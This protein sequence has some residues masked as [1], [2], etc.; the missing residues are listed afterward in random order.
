MVI[1]MKSIYDDEN[2]RQAVEQFLPVCSLE[3]GEDFFTDDEGNKDKNC[4]RQY[5]VVESLH[6]LTLSDDGLKKCIEK[7]T[8][9]LTPR[10]M[11]G[12]HADIP[13]YTI[14]LSRR[15]AEDGRLLENLKAWL[16]SDGDYD[17]DAWHHTTC[18][19][20]LPILSDEYSGKPVYYGKAQKIVNMTVK[21]VYSL[22]WVN[23]KAASTPQEQDILRKL[24]RKFESAHIPLDRFTLEWFHRR[25]AGKKTIHPRTVNGRTY[26]TYASTHFPSWSSLSYGTGAHCFLPEDAT[27]DKWQYTYPFAVEEV[28]ALFGGEVTVDGAVVSQDDPK[29]EYGS[30][31]DKY[32]GYAPLQAEF[33]IWKEMQITLAAEAFVVQ[34]KEYLDDDDAETEAKKWKQKALDEKIR[35]ALRSCLG[36]LNLVRED[37]TVDVEALRAMLNPHG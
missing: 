18:E 37:G 10:T 36:Y 33:F 4:K 27:A 31:E 26:T 35:L 11:E 12:S 34:L 5:H 17:F 7:A 28:R 25:K 22:L 29:T 6:P 21:I 32:D 24:E 13:N 30:C 8:V 3:N 19:A 1:N 2:L 9:D 23:M 20:L 15:L 16:S 14:H